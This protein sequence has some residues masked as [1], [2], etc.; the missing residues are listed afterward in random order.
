LDIVQKIRYKTPAFTVVFVPTPDKQ[1]EGKNGFKEKQDL[2]QQL[3]FVT[4]FILP[5]AQFFFR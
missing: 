3:Y 5:S 4:F 2:M 1:C